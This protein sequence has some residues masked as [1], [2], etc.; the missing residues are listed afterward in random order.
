MGQNIYHPKKH[1]KCFVTMQEEFGPLLS[2]KDLWYEKYYKIFD[3]CKQNK[4]IDYD[5]LV[6]YKKQKKLKE[7]NKL[8]H[9]LSNAI[10][11]LS[12]ELK[13]T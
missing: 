11:K 13:Y 2:N 7:E 12:N 5:L 6:W 1:N 10:T 4:S 8:N 9:E 3:L